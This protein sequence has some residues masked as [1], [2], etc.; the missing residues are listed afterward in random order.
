MENLEPL[1]AIVDE[2]R[3]KRS[4]LEIFG[5]DVIYEQG[6]KYEFSDF[7]P[8]DFNDK[9]PTIIFEDE[10]PSFCS[11][12]SEQDCQQTQTSQI[13]NDTQKRQVCHGEFALKLLS[14]REILTSDF[15][16][17]QSSPLLLSEQN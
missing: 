11:I 17:E 4:S 7:E 13:T 9:P 3:F 8:K 5:L 10:E 1:N 2:F 12:F 15:C 6:K 14:D 16:K